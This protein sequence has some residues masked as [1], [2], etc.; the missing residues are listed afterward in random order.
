MLHNIVN[1]NNVETIKLTIDFFLF[2]EIAQWSE[3]VQR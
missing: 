2:M 1:Y 3:I